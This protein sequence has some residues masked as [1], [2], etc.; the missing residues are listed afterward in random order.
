MLVLIIPIILGTAASQTLTP[1]QT[2]DEKPPRG[3][4]N[5]ESLTYSGSGCP[6]GTVHP[7]TT[8]SEDIVTMGLDA[9]WAQI[10]PNAPASDAAKSCQVNINVNFP[11]GW[12]M[13]VVD[14][15]WHGFIQMDEAVTADFYS[16]YFFSNDAAKRVS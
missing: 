15:T 9:F 6:S 10:G 1:R 5:L 16:E 2:N 13:T 4:F 7:I 8:A 12:Q 11:A 3:T 14:S